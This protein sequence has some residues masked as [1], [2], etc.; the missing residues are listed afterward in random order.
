MERVFRCN[1]TKVKRNGK[2]ISQVQKK[3]LRSEYSSQKFNLSRRREG[4]DVYLR[5]LNEDRYD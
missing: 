3:L 2:G 1:S 4:A 5:Q